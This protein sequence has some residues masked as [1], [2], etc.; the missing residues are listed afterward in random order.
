MLTEYNYTFDLLRQSVQTSLV[1]QVSHD[2]R[3][4]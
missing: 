4:L 2:D 1:E 3:S